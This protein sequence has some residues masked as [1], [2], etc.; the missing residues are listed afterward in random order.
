M[1]LLNYIRKIKSESIILCENISYYK[2]YRPV[3]VLGYT[4]SRN[5]YN[6]TDIILEIKTRIHLIKSSYSSLKLIEMT[7]HTVLLCSNLKLMEMHNEKDMFCY[8]FSV[9]SISIET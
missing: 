6:G 3:Y 5:Y 4:D 7:K 9:S 8:K 2:P 1:N